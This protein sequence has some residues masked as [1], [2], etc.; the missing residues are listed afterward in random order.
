MEDFITGLIAKTIG[1]LL[2]AVFVMFIWNTTFI[3]LFNAPRVGFWDSFIL[4]LFVHII[5]PTSSEPQNKEK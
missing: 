5:V 3:D 1:W 4:V 2:T